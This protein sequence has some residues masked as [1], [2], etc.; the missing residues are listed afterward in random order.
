V[1]FAVINE[2]PVMRIA[3]KLSVAL[4]LRLTYVQRLADL[5]ANSDRLLL[6]GPLDGAVVDF[7]TFYA[8]RQDRSPDATVYRDSAEQIINEEFGAD[9]RQTQDPQVVRGYLDD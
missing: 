3:P 8:L 9:A 1:Y 6:P 2:P 5:S 4:D 7:A